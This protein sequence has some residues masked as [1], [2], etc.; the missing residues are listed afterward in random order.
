MAGNKFLTGKTFIVEGRA[1]WPYLN[2]PDTK[3]SADG[4]YRI[5]FEVTP[6]LRDRLKVEAEATYQAAVNKFGSALGQADLEAAIKPEKAKNAA[7]E[8]VPTGRDLVEFKM[9]AK[10]KTKTG[11]IE[12]RPILVD[13]KRVPVTEKVFGGSLVKAA[14][15]FQFSETSFGTHVSPRLKG[16]QVI[17]LVGPDGETAE[18]LFDEQDGFETAGGEGATPG[19]PPADEGSDEGEDF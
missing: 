13:A 12:Q 17:E 15:Y 6:E 1:V 4:D 2:D 16:V 19:A 14:V 5:G 7:G 11:V 3:F 9:R 18:S 10:R 8:R